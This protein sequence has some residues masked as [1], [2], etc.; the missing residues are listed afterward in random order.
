MSTKICKICNQEKEIKFYRHQRRK[1]DIIYTRPNCKDCDN[2]IKRET[3][4]FHWDRRMVRQSKKSDLK[5]GFDINKLITRDFILKQHRA[6]KNKCMYCNCVMK[7]GIGI[8]R[9]EPNGLSLERISSKLP[10][11]NDNCILTCYQCNVMKNDMEFKE[12]IEKCGVI[13]KR[14]RYFFD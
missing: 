7:S 8:N 1:Y 14:Y 4:Q 3:D 9:M 2:K 11:T 13:Y 12:F 5:K 10:H 6:Q